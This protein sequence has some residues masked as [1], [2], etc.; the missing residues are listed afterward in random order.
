MGDKSNIEWTDATWN[1]FYGCRKVSPGCKHC[2]MYRDME[3]FGRDPFTVK[4]AADNT[5]RAPLRWAKSGKVA[6]GSR[7]FTCSWSDFFIEDADDWRGEAWDIIRATPQYTYQILTKRPENIADRLPSDWGAGWANV[8]L[9]VSA[10]NQEQAD[11]RI[12]LLLNTPAIIRFVSAEP[13]LGPVYMMRHLL[14][15]AHKWRQDLHWVIVGGE[16]GPRRRPFDPDWARSIRDQCRDAGVPFFFK[17]VDKVQPIP[18]DLLIREWPQAV[19][20]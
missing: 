8:W 6:S 1:P 18:N 20:P 16:S 5:F 14:N 13:L 9:G 12:P 3:R 10:E 7:I 19:N 4:R 17:Q 2:Y 15:G 11:R